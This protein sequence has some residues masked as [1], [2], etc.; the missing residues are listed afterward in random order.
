M[1]CITVFS[2]TVYIIVYIL[3][4]SEYLWFKVLNHFNGEFTLLGSFLRWADRCTCTHQQHDDIEKS[5]HH[6]GVACSLMFHLNPWQHG[7]Q[8][9]FFFS[10][11]K[12]PFFGGN[13]FPWWILNVGIT[14]QKSH[15]NGKPTIWRGMPFQ[16]WW[17]SIVK[18]WFW[19]V[20]PKVME[21]KSQVLD[22]NTCFD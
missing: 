10:T 3:Y 17:C 5:A 12:T 15:D 18:F 14:P 13:R 19:G 7:T 20:T 9:V 16:K 2:R 4:L 11:G 6:T 21:T 1:D 22:L 8:G